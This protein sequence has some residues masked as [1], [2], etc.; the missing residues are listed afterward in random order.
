MH[1]NCKKIGQYSMTEINPNGIGRL[2][3]KEWD[4]QKE[5]SEV[6]GIPQ[7]LI[8]MCCYGK[9][10]SAGGYYWSFR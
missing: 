6:L 4:S 1:G 7:P 10:K 3:I 8:S 9:I 2:L 5:A